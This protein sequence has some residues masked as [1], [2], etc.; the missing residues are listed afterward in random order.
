MTR[1][2][3]V[4]TL[5]RREVSRPKRVGTFTVEA[6]IQRSEELRPARLGPGEDDIQDPAMPLGSERPARSW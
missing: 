2:L 5:I 4:R 1:I 3:R 6:D